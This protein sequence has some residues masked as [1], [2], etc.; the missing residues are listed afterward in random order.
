MMPHRFAFLVWTLTFSLAGALEEGAQSAEL[1]GFVVADPL[2]CSYAEFPESLIIGLT[3][4]LEHKDPQMRRSAAALLDKF[5]SRAMSAVPSLIKALADKDMGVQQEAAWALAAIARRRPSLL[6]EALASQDKQ[7]RLGILKALEGISSL[8]SFDGLPRAE[9][10]TVKAVIE[11][12]KDRDPE[13]RKRAVFVLGL[14]GDEIAI[15]SL[16]DRVKKD[17]EREVRI[18]SATSLAWFAKIAK[19]AI[20]TLVDGL[21]RRDNEE[22]ARYAWALAQIGR[23]AVPSLIKTIQDPKLVHLYIE[24]ADGLG[25]IGPDACEATGALAVLLQ[26]ED[27]D[28]RQRVA[29]ALGQIGPKAKSSLPGLSLAAKNSSPLIGIRI[30]Q[31]MFKI[32]ADNTG[33]LSI[34]LKAMKDDDSDIRNMAIEVFEE[35]G[36][37]AAKAVPALI[38]ALKDIEISV[39]TAAARALA[40]IGPD[41]RDAIPA[42]EAMSEESGALGQ[43]VDCALKSIRKVKK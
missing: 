7:V 36:P 25:T 13:V 26:S 31:A 12:L 10:T 11:V 42:L 18:Y 43:A 20:P 16:I 37:K 9:T 15:P 23:D 17:P 2:R 4:C 32:H 40:A 27:E 41:A 1:T 35:M 14:F 39:R 3:R 5:G 6:L 33:S 24:L 34:L 19:E 29:W 21:K 22:A 30:A 28:L 8:N 38:V